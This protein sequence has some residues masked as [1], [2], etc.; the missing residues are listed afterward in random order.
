MDKKDI[1]LNSSCRALIIG[2]SGSIGLALIASLKEK[3]GINNVIG[4]SRLENGLDLTDPKTIALAAEKQS[5]QFQ[6]ILDATGALEINGAGPEKSFR[7][8]EYSNMLDQFK[9]NAIGPAM[10]IKHFMEFLPKYGKS[11]FMTLSARVG[12][13]GDNKL[14]GW[15]SYRSSKSALNQ[16][17]K[18]AAVELTRKNPE[19]VCIALHPGTVKSK[20]TH[21]YL[22]S[23]PYVEP[24]VAAQ[25]I[26]RVIEQKS[27]QDS[28]GFYDY[29]GNIIP[30]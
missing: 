26:I 5:G 3:I 22:G 10:V 12:S 28:G 18:T 19:S 6:L 30:W 29:R 15:V 7:S 23:H 25:N 27:S 13:I 21:K 4:I 17:V 24:E 9:V 16:I 11:V 14:G 20:L 1:F 2:S 8:L